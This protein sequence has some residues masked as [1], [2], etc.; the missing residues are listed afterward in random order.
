MQ[1]H[2]F[3]STCVKS[4]VKILASSFVAE[5]VDKQPLSFLLLSYSGQT[6]EVHSDIS[7]KGRILTL[8]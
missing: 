8:L 7:G 4:N 1:S 3:S 2:G 6:L 5:Q